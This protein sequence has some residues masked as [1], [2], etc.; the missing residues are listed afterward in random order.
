MHNNWTKIE[1]RGQYEIGFADVYEL[2]DDVLN[3]IS[4]IYYFPQFQDSSKQTVEVTLLLKTP[5][6]QW[7]D[8]GIKRIFGDMEEIVKKDENI[9]FKIF[10]KLDYFNTKVL[11][12]DNFNGFR[13]LNIG[14]WSFID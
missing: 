2:Q 7:T 14:E 11:F 3:A 5:E 12:L 4:I 6:N 8:G 13:L 10:N 1:S 9:K